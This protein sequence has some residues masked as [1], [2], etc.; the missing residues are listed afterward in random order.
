MTTVDRLSKANTIS[1]GDLVPVWVGSDTDVR[2]V[3]IKVLAQLIKTLL[4]IPDSISFNTQYV[5]PNTDFSMTL[6]SNG[7]NIW[8]VMTPTTDIATGTLLMPAVAT[9]LHNQE[10]LVN[11]TT[12]ITSFTVDGNGGNVV[13][14][15][16][17]ITAGDSFRFRF[18]AVTKTWYR[19][20]YAYQIPPV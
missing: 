2:R 3:T 9:C 12:A 16:S 18:D 13:N 20:D 8:L 19:T 6:I 17:S 5:A 15:P 11:C 10:I 14:P 7:V 4:G 1:Q